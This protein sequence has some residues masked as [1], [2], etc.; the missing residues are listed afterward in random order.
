VRFKNVGEKP[1][2]IRLYLDDFD[3]EIIEVLKPGSM[4]NDWMHLDEE[5]IIE[6]SVIMDNDVEEIKTPA[7]IITTSEEEA[8][9]NED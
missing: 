6:I 2:K 9:E 4:G 3:E 7:V 8:R 1:I 5:D